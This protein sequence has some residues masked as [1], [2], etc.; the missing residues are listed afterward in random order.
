[1]PDGVDIEQLVH[2]TV[3]QTG[4]PPP[5][6]LETDA[7]TLAL[8]D[9]SSSFYLVGLIGGKEVGKSAMVNALAGQTISAVTSHGAGTNT[10]VAYAH[11]SRQ[12]AVRELLEREAPGQYRIVAHS[13][14]GEQARVLLDLPDIDSHFQSHLLLTRRMLRH[15][16][17]PIWMVSIEK[18]ADAQPRQMLA[19]VAEG[20]DPQ[21]FL[22]VLNKADQLDDDAVTEIR[23]DYARRL[24][25]TMVVESPQVWVVSALHPDR[26][27]LPAL[28]KTLSRDRSTSEVT[29]SRQL[30]GLRRDAS[31]VRWLETQN[32]PE[33][34][35]R[36]ERLWIDARELLTARLAG[37]LLE[38]AIPRLADDVA[39]RATLTDQAMAARVARWP[40]VNLV[41]TLLAPILSAA[42]ALVRGGTARAMGT[43]A[44]LVDAHLTVDGQ[45][46][47]QVVQATF[48]HVHQTSPIVANLYAHR[49]PWEGRG[50]E[51]A[52]YSLRTAAIDTIER[53]RAEV[54]ARLGA[55]RNPISA[56][57]RWTLTIGA[58]LWFPFIQPFL[59]VALQTSL[60][61]AIAKLGLL[62]V[63][64][65][66]TTYLLTTAGF[67][68]VYFTV[69]WLWL[70]WSTQRKVAK[71]LIRWSTGRGSDDLDLS[72]QTM[73]WIDGLSN[74]LRE[75]HEIAVGLAERVSKVNGKTAA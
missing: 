54:V 42:I 64:L 45:P 28:R 55:S 21:N 71:S 31:L 3:E 27:D 57:T 44:G 72:R 29:T 59:E 66:G 46:L 6:L 26:Y 60:N 65:L 75:A 62:I 18:Y 50:A 5:R 52:A 37:P 49:R 41:H 51:Q 16:L 24:A 22:F 12:T 9:N 20:N 11:T 2:D 1:M 70:R 61:E 19:R 14:A 48:A 74:P 53:Q 67:L 39:Y 40:L 15:M 4:A 73:A 33:R 36:L 7:P 32:L 30:A 25:A 58:L 47:H 68:V 23:D 17:Y 69:I 56:L 38:R 8:T 63:Q 10:V 43:S 34:A 13:M 35:A